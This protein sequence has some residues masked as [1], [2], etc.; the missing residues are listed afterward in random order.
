MHRLVGGAG[1]G[2]ENVHNNIQDYPTLFDNIYAR[3]C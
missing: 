2:E 3:Y 1:D